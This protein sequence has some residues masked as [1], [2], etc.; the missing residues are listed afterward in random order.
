MGGAKI[1]LLVLNCQGDLV[2]IYTLSE[3]PGQTWQK[4]K[5]LRTGKKYIWLAR[6]NIYKPNSSEHS[7]GMRLTKIS[8]RLVHLLAVKSFTLEA[9]ACMQPWRRLYMGILFGGDGAVTSADF[10]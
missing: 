5:G 8:T 9:A 10:A 1:K 7:L 3:S 6:L 4:G 2:T